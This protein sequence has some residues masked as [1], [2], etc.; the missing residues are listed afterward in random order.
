[1]CSSALPHIVRRLD[2]LGALRLGEMD[3]GGIDIQVLSHAAP[4]TQK[5]DPETAVRVA[6]NV[7]DRPKQKID[8]NPHR[9]QGD[10]KSGGEGK[11][12]DPG[13]RRIIKK[14]KTN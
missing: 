11:S 3:E 7:N 4:S 2:D 8:G 10:R 12:V 6:R 14:K 1:M 5:L 13:G 9:F